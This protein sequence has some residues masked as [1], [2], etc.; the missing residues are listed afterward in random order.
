MVP[1]LAARAA[2]RMEALDA[3][4]GSAML[5]VFFAHFCDAFFRP[6]VGTNNHH[7]LLL[8]TRMA[9]PA[10]M[11]ISGLML[12]ILHHG[13]RD[14]F[15]ALRDRLI[16]RGLFL[17]LVG[18]PLLTVA[19]IWISTTWSEA[20]RVL[21]ITDT[22]GFCLIVGSLLVTR[23]GPGARVLVGAGLLF[24]AWV[25]LMFW[26]PDADG[27]AWWAKVV[28]IGV[29]GSE[30][31]T[32][33]F[34]PLP[35]LGLYLMASALGGTFARLYEQGDHRRLQITVLSTGLAAI[36]IGL[37]LKEVFA[38]S[39]GLVSSASF[40][41]QLISLGSLTQKM[42]PSPAYLTFYGG[43][44]LVMLSFLLAIERT[45][46][47][48][49]F[50][51]WAALFGRTSLACFVAQFYVYYVSVFL[52]PRPPVIFVS[53]YF[54]ATLVLLRVIARAWDAANGNRL[55]TVGYPRVAQRWRSARSDEHPT[56]RPGY[57]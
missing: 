56:L 30:G 18:H 7:P 9:S 13:K 52:L 43:A 29:W 55:I 26:M 54:L 46:V 48:K 40:A 16:D 22:I 32:Y 34:P 11:S 27:P 53:I 8:L 33:N 44:A 25:L 51:R 47:G 1:D 6:F 20:V 57:R 24:T 12:G 4:R 10:F 14:R 36:S 35:W 3:A 19:M 37:L 5:L 23:L 50:I 21:F 45:T 31:L 49:M 15:G 17:V 42:P 39:A 38:H 41:D 2:K 28:L